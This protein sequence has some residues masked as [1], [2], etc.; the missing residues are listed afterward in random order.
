MA[1][2]LLLVAGPA[3]TSSTRIPISRR[4]RLDQG[5]GEDDQSEGVRSGDLSPPDSEEEKR[6]INDSCLIRVLR[7]DQLSLHEHIR[8]LE[9][10]IRVLEEKHK[11]E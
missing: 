8:E 10:R 9:S 6:K 1:E 2:Q 3:R 7:E 4:V 5:A 11:D